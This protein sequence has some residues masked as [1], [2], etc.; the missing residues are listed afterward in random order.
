MDIGQ[1]PMGIVAWHTRVGPPR[2]NAPADGGGSACSAGARMRRTSMT[3]TPVGRSSLL[4]VLLLG[5]L[6]SACSSSGTT[7]DLA[8]TGLTYAVNPAVYA[9]GTQITPNTPHSSGGAVVTYSVLPALP[10]GLSLNTT[11]GVLSGMPTAVAAVASYTVTAT[12]SAG[13][14]TV[15]LSITV[16]AVVVA[17]AGLTYAVNPAVYTVDVAFTGNTPHSSGGAVVT[18]SVLPNLP[19][20]LSLNTTTGALSGMPTAVAAVASYTVTAANSAG[21]T[22]VGLSI[23][24][25]AAVVVYGQ[26]AAST[27]GVTF[28]TTSPMGASFQAVPPAPPPYQ[29]TLTAMISGSSGITSTSGAFIQYSS[30]Q[31]A[32]FTPQQC[33]VTSAIPQCQTTVSFPASAPTAI[34][35]QVV[36]QIVAQYSGYTAIA[37]NATPSTTPAYGDIT[38][39][40]QA[41]NNVANGMKAPLFVNWDNHGQSD[42]VTV[43][44]SIVGSGVSFYS[45]TPGDNGTMVTS[46][47]QTCTLSYS[48][49]P[50]SDALNCG[51]GLVGSATTGTATINAIA[52]SS[53]Q[54]AYVITPLTLSVVP[55]GPARRSITFTNNSSRTIYVG[56]TGGAA[57]SYL[58]PS[59]TAVP[60]GPPG[61]NQKAGAGSLC[62]PSNPQAACPI[63]TTCIQ[64]GTSP[65]SDI[66]KTPFYCFYDQNIPTSGYQIA[67]NGGSTV[68]DISGTSLSPSGIIWSGNLYARTGCKTT[69]GVCENATCVGAAGGLACGPGTGAHPGV[70]TLAELTF[71]A[72]PN[73]DFYDVS[74]ING[75]NFA[76]QF[77]PTNV[78]VSSTNAYSCGLAGSLVAQNGGYPNGSPPT[79]A[80]LPAANWTMTPTTASFPPGVT[81]TGD[82]PSNYRVVASSSGTA[83][84]P[85]ASSG[86]CTVAPDTTCGYEM[87]GV[88]TGTFPFSALT[89]GKPVA[90]LTADAIWGLNSTSTNVAPFAFATS[91]PNGLSGTGTV[92]VGD[93]QLC[94]NSTYSAYVT[95]WTTASPPAPIQPL[96]LA[97]GGVMWG[98]TESPPQNPTGNIGLN[99]TRPSQLV[100]TANTNWLSY[101]L[102][103]ITWLKQ[104]CPTCYTYPFDDMTSTFTCLETTDIQP[105]TNYGVTFSDLH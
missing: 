71:Q 3:S 104:A 54:H 77:G 20:G 105:I 65:H 90:W 37:V 59:K 72:Y 14:T 15:G 16:H 88:V 83:G 38:I 50:A 39:S 32:T 93:L 2:L 60:P 87:T 35:V 99:L 67:A 68:L 75:V 92:S 28:V 94:I 31:G 66:S 69:T 34:S 45:Y 8:P 70:N 7:P 22:T 74:I 85:C 42:T 53:A 51:F 61:P 62:G 102:P 81:V 46:Q 101:V 26:L 6:G 97:C 95:N 49:V 82:A 23:T 48:G 44:L 47:T 9:V 41:G 63:G 12:N 52:T 57:N 4:A 1:V 98:A 36:G 73:P 21:S 80:G 11:T 19:A 96:A 10:A 24:V 103:T 40:T 100:Q 43:S 56:I 86:T 78:A 79:T 30:T 76:T 84:Q 13:S 55:P 33:A 89:C 5:V 27:D 17:P 64:G 91:W 29:M 25:N 18:Y 58:T